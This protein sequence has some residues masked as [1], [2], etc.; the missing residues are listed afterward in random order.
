MAASGS[1]Q[2]WAL[3]R[4]QQIID[5]LPEDNLLEVI[6]YASTLQSAEEVAEYFKNLL[7]DSNT[8]L[9]F[10]TD[11]NARQFRTSPNTPTGNNASNSANSS[12]TGSPAPGNQNR[13]GKKGKAPLH[14][15]QQAPRQA[16]DG[17]QQLFAN[18]QGV[19][20]KSNKDLE[21][22]FYSGTRRS[23]TPK[24]TENAARAPPTQAPPVGLESTTSFVAKPAKIQEKQASSSSNTK[25]DRKKGEKEK[26][27]IVGGT[28]MRGASAE[29]TDLELA[30]RAL[31]MSTN[32]T[33]NSGRKL[34]LCQGLVHE[35]FQATPNCTNCGKIIC[36]KEGLGPCTWCSAPMLTNDE[37]QDM[38]RSLREE[39]V[40]ERQGAANGGRGVVEGAVAAAMKPVVAQDEGLRKAEEHRNRLLGFQASS[41][42]R[43]KIIDQASD[44]EIPTASGLNQWATPAERA[45]QLKRQQKTMK[46][47]NWNA[48]EAY[49]K[50]RVV[51][52]IDLKGKKV[53][54]EM[55]EIEG[56]SNSDSEEEDQGEADRSIER[57]GAQ[58]HKTA[59]QRVEREGGGRFSHNP[60]LRGL[61]K[62]VYTPEGNGKETEGVLK[63]RVFK[64]R[65]V[66]DSLEDNEDVILDGGVKGLSDTMQMERGD[67]VA[68]G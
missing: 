16:N 38:I 64:W 20:I 32:S 36:I 68:C 66:Q 61:V 48:Q 39:A 55:R 14:S 53:V 37:V 11:F 67:E 24:P 6:T 2:A 41:A 52:A 65:R 57:G 59:G 26:F 5:Y 31:E 18:P 60:L 13:R 29:R 49:Q 7:G 17:Q 63:D 58:A 4:I 30:I 35:V 12:R 43:T 25:S 44:F 62:P 56:P 50:R 3:P 51:V 42:Q 27:S 54:R 22:S 47:I 46:M 10:I 34:C 23:T 33:L 45:L 1:I 28:P 19:Y 15:F 8:A 21:D 40:R 9:N